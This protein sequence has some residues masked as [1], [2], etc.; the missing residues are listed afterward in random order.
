MLTF[1]LDPTE[2]DPEAAD[3][4]DPEAD[5]VDV[6]VEE[7]DIEIFQAIFLCFLYFYSIV[8]G[9]RCTRRKRKWPRS[10]WSFHESGAQACGCAAIPGSPANRP[11]IPVWK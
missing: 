1:R 7:E 8:N 6:A 5:A 10:W 9:N 3:V 2:N 11:R 4:A